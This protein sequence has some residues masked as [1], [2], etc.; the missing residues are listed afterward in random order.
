MIKPYRAE[1]HKKL[2]AVF[3][4]N[5]PKYFDEKETHDFEQYLAQNGDTYFTYWQEQEIVGGTGYYVNESEKSG[6]IT[7][8]FFAPEHTRKGLGRAAVKH[9]LSLLAKDERVKKHRV[10]TSQLAHKFF[11]QFGFKTIRMEKDYWGIGLDLYEMEMFK[12]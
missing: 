7:W 2:I 6:S 1:D 8:I 4:L 12:P 10:T 5:V 3:K 9:C 11:E